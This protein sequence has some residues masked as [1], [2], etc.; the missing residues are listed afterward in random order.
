MRDGGCGSWPATWPARTSGSSPT[1]QDHAEAKLCAE[2][3][4]AAAVK[5]RA[6]DRINSIRTLLA[7]PATALILARTFDTNP[8]PPAIQEQVLS[9]VVAH[10]DGQVRDL[11]ERF[12]RPEQRVE[13]LGTAFDTAQLLARAGDVARG[14][15]IYFDLAGIQ[16]KNCHRIGETGGTVG[17]DLDHIGKKYNRAQLLE[18]IV[19]PSKTV[20]PK[21]TVY[22][23]ETTTGKTLSGQLVERTADQIVLKD[24]EGKLL[25]VASGEVEKLSP[26]TRSLMPDQMLRDMTAQ[27]AADLLEYLDSLK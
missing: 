15:E 3:E 2:K 8:L 22:L 21:Y 11:F 1:E 18:S 5:N 10:S 24:A 9:A 7:S 19:E 26:Q 13:R 17:P 16:C 25:T 14:R 20:D 6:A 27:Q 23:L 4:I 12:V